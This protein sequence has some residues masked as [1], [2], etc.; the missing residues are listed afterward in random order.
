MSLRPAHESIIDAIEQY[1]STLQRGKE[2][3]AEGEIVGEGKPLR[4]GLEEAIKG[5]EIGGL[6][7]L[8]DLLKVT[9]IPQDKLGEIIARLRRIDHHHCAIHTTITILEER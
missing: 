9:I 4:P 3:A 1:A 8:L 6:C 7:A 2:R 5:Q